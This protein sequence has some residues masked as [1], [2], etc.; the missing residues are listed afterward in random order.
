M[1]VI[2]GP[3][4]Y[5]G[6]GQGPAPEG[7]TIRRLRAGGFGHGKARKL[8]SYASFAVGA[9][10]EVAA[11]PRVDVMVSMTTPPLLGLLGWVAQW[12]GARHYIWEMDVYPDVAVELGVF[13][14]GGLADRVTGWL[15]DLPRRRANGIIAL[16]PCMEER[17]RRR[18]LAHTP[19][20]VVHNWA[21]GETMRPREFARDG[22]L[23]IFYS[24]NMGLAHDFET[25][26]PVARA[27]GDGFLFRFSGAGPRRA[28][29]ESALGDLAW[30]RFQGYH[31]REELEAAFGENDIGLVTQQAATVG[32]VV[33]SKAYGVM[34]AGR[35]V[36]Y[37][38]PARS[39]VGRMIGEHGV[40]WQVENGDMAGLRS[41]LERLRARP[42]EVEETGR[43]ARAVFER[44]FERRGQV[45]KIWGILAGLL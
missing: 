25:V 38:G 15:A 3:A 9:A 16:G 24:G 33:P 32:T 2:C 14:R 41:L 1:T 13:A 45:E 34:A 30:C 31:R 12:R 8:L 28:E 10:W 44:E 18:G 7:V 37:V 21:D 35:G 20:F 36:L 19:I 22:V 4:A 5:V 6:G 42:D 29:V 17:L 27:L 40:G 11:G 26:V 39:T 43:R 23:K